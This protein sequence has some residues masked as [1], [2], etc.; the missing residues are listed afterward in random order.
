[1]A[2]E[3]ARVAIETTRVGNELSTFEQLFRDQFGARGVAHEQSV[4]AVGSHPRSQMLRH[5]LAS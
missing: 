4:L 1:M 3:L 5:V 2:V